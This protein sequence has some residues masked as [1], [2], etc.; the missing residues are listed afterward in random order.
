[1]KKIISFFVVGFAIGFFICN[2]FCF[3]EPKENIEISP[4][5]FGSV[6]H[7][8]LPN[9]FSDSFDL[10]NKIVL[11]ILVRHSLSLDTNKLCD[12]ERCHSIRIE[13]DKNDLIVKK[14]MKQSNC[15]TEDAFSL[16]A[17]KI[18]DYHYEYSTIDGVDGFETSLTLYDYSHGKMI[19]IK[20]PPVL[21]DVPNA[22][23][24]TTLV[25]QIF[26]SCKDTL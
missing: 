11:D 14:Y 1:M 7:F 26:E 5:A 24:I 3:Y 13:K 4:L 12:S 22:M 25:N 2:R 19:Y 17:E 18:L 16:L 10:K 8:D 23:K 20:F 21:G 6:M 15:I 9:T